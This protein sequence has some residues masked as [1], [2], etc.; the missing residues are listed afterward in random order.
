MNS[1]S[2]EGLRIPLDDGRSGRQRR[3]RNRCMHSHSIREL[4]ST[5]MKRESKKTDG[6]LLLWMLSQQHQQ[7]V[8]CTAHSKHTNTII[9]VTLL[10]LLLT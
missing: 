3:R 4:A 2:L 6:I 8:F 9:T 1:S 7:P 5:Q 10:F